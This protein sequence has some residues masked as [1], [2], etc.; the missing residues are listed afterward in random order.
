[1]GQLLNNIECISGATILGDGNVALILDVYKLIQQV[2]T[3]EYDHN[4]YHLKE[5]YAYTPVTA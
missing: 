3:R 4:G 1:M 5:I 2:E